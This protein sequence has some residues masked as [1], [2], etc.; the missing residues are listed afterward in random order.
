[1]ARHSIKIPLQF[2][3]LVSNFR[4]SSKKLVVDIS[5]KNPV[6][7]FSG[8]LLFIGLGCSLKWWYNDQLLTVL[9]KNNLPALSEPQQ[10][11]SRETGEYVIV[12]QTDQLGKLTKAEQD[13][14]SLLATQEE[15]TALRACF[16]N[17]VDTAADSKDRANNSNNRE[18]AGVNNAQLFDNLIERIDLYANSVVVKLKSPWEKHAYHRFVGVFPE[19]L[20]QH[21]ALT[22]PIN[23]GGANFSVI[24][25]VHK[26]LDN[27]GKPVRGSFT[28]L[29]NKVNDQG[30]E[31]IDCAC[32]PSEQNKVSNVN[33]VAID[34]ISDADCKVADRVDFTNTNQRKLIRET[35]NGQKYTFWGPIY[36]ESWFKLSAR[37]LCVNQHHTLANFFF[38]QTA[39][40]CFLPKLCSAYYPVPFLGKINKLTPNLITQHP[41]FAISP[42]LRRTVSTGCG[43][44]PSGMQSCQG[45]NQDIPKNDYARTAVWSSVVNNNFVNFN[46]RFQGK[47]LRHN[48]INSTDVQPV[49]RNSN[50]GSKRFIGKTNQPD[51]A[52]HINSVNSC[53]ISEADS[54][55]K[56]SAISCF[57]TPVQSQGS[58]NSKDTAAYSINCT[59]LA[60]PESGP[61]KFKKLSYPLELTTTMVG[62]QPPIDTL[63]LNSYLDEIPY[64]LET[65][66]PLLSGK[67][68]NQLQDNCQTAQ[69]PKSNSHKNLIEI[70]KLLK[71]ELFHLVH[72]LSIN[73]C[74]PVQSVPPQ[75]SSGL[76]SPGRLLPHQLTSITKSGA[77]DAS[78]LV[79]AVGSKKDKVDIGKVKEKINRIG[80]LL[81][82]F[83]ED[84]VEQM[85]QDNVLEKANDTSCCVNDRNDLKKE[86]IDLENSKNS[87]DSLSLL[88]NLSITFNNLS[89]LDTPSILSPINEDTL[90]YKKNSINSGVTSSL[91]TLPSAE[92][93]LDSS[94]KVVVKK[95]TLTNIDHI[96][97]VD[98]NISFS[99]TKS[100]LMSGYV[101]P[102]MKSKYLESN[103]CR[104]LS[105]HLL[106]RKIHINPVHLQCKSLR[107][108]ST[109]VVATPVA[110]QTSQTRIPLSGLQPS[111]QLG[112]PRLLPHSLI[113]TAGNVNFCAIDASLAQHEGCKSINSV[114]TAADSKELACGA[115]TNFIPRVENMYINL[116][117]R[118]SRA[119]DQACLV[120]L[121]IPIT[122]TTS[123]RQSILSTA[124][125][126]PLASLVS[127]DF[128]NNTTT[129]PVKPVKLGY[130]SGPTFLPTVLPALAGRL[131]A[132]GLAQLPE[133]L[134]DYKNVAKHDVWVATSAAV[135]TPL[136]KHA[137]RVATTP[138]APAAPLATLISQA[139]PGVQDKSALRG[140]DSKNKV[141]A[142]LQTLSTPPQKKIFYHSTPECV[143]EQQNLEHRV[144]VGVNKYDKDRGA[145]QITNLM[146]AIMA[147]KKADCNAHRYNRK[148]DYRFAYFPGFTEPNQF[149]QRVTPDNNVNSSAIN[150]QA[151]PRDSI[152][153][154]LMLGA[155]PQPNDN[156]KVTQKK[157]NNFVDCNA[158]KVAYQGIVVQR[159]QSTKDFQLQN[160][161]S[162]S[163]LISSITPSDALSA[164]AI[165]VNQSMIRDHD[166]LLVKPINYVD[167]PIECVAVQSMSGNVNG[168][169]KVAPQDVER[170]AKTRE[171]IAKQ[172]AAV[173][174]NCKDKEADCRDNAVENCSSWATHFLGPEN[175]L[176]DRQSHFFGQRRLDTMTTKSY[177]RDY[178][179]HLAKET[180]A[181]STPKGFTEKSTSVERLK[182]LSFSK[183][184][185]SFP[186]KKRKYAYL[187]EKNDEWHLLFQEQFRAALQDPKKY[188]PLTPEE[189]SS[190]A[191]SIN[192]DHLSGRIKVTAPLATARFPAK[193][194]PKQYFTEIDKWNPTT[195]LSNPELICAPALSGLQPR[196]LCMPEVPID[197]INRLLPHPVLTNVELRSQTKTKKLIVK[198]LRGELAKTPIIC[199]YPLP[200]E[201]MLA[202]LNGE[203]WFNGGTVSIPLTSSKRKGGA[204]SK[205]GVHN[206]AFK[207]LAFTMLDVATQEPLTNHSWHII[208]Q[209]SFLVALLFWVEQMLLEGVFPAL[210]ALE[211]LLLGAIDMKSSDR[212]RVIRVIKGDVNTPKFQDIAGVDGL[213]GELSELVL[214]LR[215][216]KEQL[217]CAQ[218]SHGVL[219]TGPPGTGKTFLVRALAGEAKVP[220]LILSAGAL[221]ASKV[222][223]NKPSWSIR[224]AFRRAKQLAPCILFIDELDALGASRGGVVTDI[225]EIVAH[226]GNH[227]KNREPSGQR[228]T[229]S[230]SNS[231]AADVIDAAPPALAEH[232]GSK[233]RIEG[234]NRKVEEREGISD[235]LEGGYVNRDKDRKNRVRPTE[236]Q[237][238]KSKFGPLTQLL[239]S[240]DGVN[241]LSGVLVLGAT[242]RPESL[243]PALT[244]PGRFERVIRVEKPAEEKRIEILRLYSRKLGVQQKIPW[245]YLANRTV[246][247]T[248]ADLAVAMNYS[249]LKAILQGSM[250]TVE[251]V[252]YGLD[253]IVRFGKKGTL[254]P[255][256]LR[257]ESTLTSLSTGLSVGTQQQLIATTGAKHA[258][259]E[260]SSVPLPLLAPGN[261]SST[262]ESK[263]DWRSV[264]S[265]VQ[266]AEQAITNH[267]TADE[268]DVN[269]VDIQSKKRRNKL[270]ER[271]SQIAYYQ[272][273]KVVV[274]TLLPLHPPVALVRMNLSGITAATA[275]DT[276]IPIDNASSA[277]WRSSLESRLV[278][279]YGG[280]AAS[281]LILSD[282]ISKKKDGKISFHSSAIP[283]PHSSWDVSLSKRR[284]NPKHQQ[285]PVFSSRRV[286]K[287]TPLTTSALAGLTPSALST[288]V[289]SA[290][291]Q[292]ATLSTPLTSIA[293]I[294]KTKKLMAQTLPV[295]SQGDSRSRMDLRVIH[296]KTNKLTAISCAQS[297]LGS[298]ELKA[299]TDLADRMVNEWN[300]YSGGKQHFDSGSTVDINECVAVQSMS[301]SVAP[302]P[303]TWSM[304]FAPV[305]SAK[306]TTIQNVSQLIHLLHLST[307]QRDRLYPSWFR[308]YLPDIEATELM[309]NAAD[310]YLN[311]TLGLENLLNQSTTSINGMYATQCAARVASSMMHVL[312]RTV[313][314]YDKNEMLELPSGLA[315]FTGYQYSARKLN[316]VD[317]AS[318]IAVNS[319]AFSAQLKHRELPQVFDKSA[320]RAC[321]VNTVHTAADSKAS[322][323]Q[324][325][326][327]IS[328]SK[329]TT[330][331]KSTDNKGD[332]LQ[333]FI[334]KID[335]DKPWLRVRSQRGDAK[336]I[337]AVCVNE[338]AIDVNG[339][340][341][342][343]PLATH[344]VQ[345]QSALRACKAADSKDKGK[346]SIRNFHSSYKR[347]E[348]T[349]LHKQTFSIDCNDL[350]IIEKEFFYHALV[351]NCFTKAFVLADQ[352]RQLLDYFADYLLRFQIIRQD[353][354][355]Y[356]FST[357]LLNRCNLFSISSRRNG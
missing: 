178:L 264:R 257:A 246:G 147:S 111:A 309:K 341:P 196:Q 33:E 204:D 280:K 337:D 115:P 299:G 351:T 181:Q 338:C 60:R 175:P 95:T 266:P 320:L 317:I 323:S 57:T 38:Q 202:E 297:D 40:F 324:N 156:L 26:Y 305:Q 217:F 300:F 333:Y 136:T 250:H 5:S 260:D 117:R 79:N 146:G 232:E 352:N 77:H 278:G 145:Q 274:Q 50:T 209:W 328:R 2:S 37:G 158:R 275:A 140:T 223:S 31:L 165:D 11:I 21:V 131:D 94:N 51:F 207:S 193:R 98:K 206:D 46:N 268:K 69:T 191:K 269:F 312:P 162:D 92:L 102:D 252:E 214:F 87:L 61:F 58:I 235:F 118:M 128:I 88:G 28:N 237:K 349:V 80:S 106:Q 285:K 1:M 255:L 290:S 253:S 177:Q 112:I 121:H 258:Q 334:H 184:L 83:P 47:T 315:G 192:S 310:Y 327:A 267:S 152:A 233:V 216:H 96:N 218:R 78:L 347:L 72:S 32:S 228:L 19:N 138:Y 213:L 53:A 224:H 239:V 284:S 14:S 215:G 241:N 340:A 350:S 97:T 286:N 132:S 104:W 164:Y 342:T 314:G 200:R 229:F 173:D 179:R 110:T 292:S 130:S 7:N 103:L 16:V 154:E 230:R 249:S 101:Y 120:D 68:K 39:D 126:N 329:A 277:H 199:H 296:R 56:S 113:Q 167:K 168:V 313:A 65:Y 81:S 62:W 73:L 318:E 9:L 18:I 75:A 85:D 335:K 198:S 240:M 114:D 135:S 70:K 354:I 308:L 30:A 325:E 295:K 345:D 180:L 194:S 143:T 84:E 270:I 322:N 294:A 163:L 353:K 282:F 141:L 90:F 276:Y 67:G 227:N 346:N 170:S 13:R 169:N 59:S 44:N 157:L 127:I 187:L 243:D 29:L 303:L 291:L 108:L 151:T 188:P 331:S 186:L 219:L 259:P 139:Q 247:L 27:N 226:I 119:L 357:L 185:S 172:G 63:I 36:P 93:S 222:N 189:R 71:N 148:L 142:G 100:R 272:A 344:W 86:L 336:F 35:I 201:T 205:A 123:H 339:C 256:S 301:A 261:A 48:L 287:S 311:G 129:Q 137:R 89:A 231:Y 20:N 248:A 298:G 245:A 356:L 55:D 265:S 150:V 155:P 244:R 43:S 12:E 34:A 109:D 64:K 212:A 149:F 316:S 107:A 41:F 99:D 273:G 279:L 263:A 171:L 289:Q 161:S 203:S 122:S 225:N 355:L 159:N 288:D 281:L 251:T 3:I 302:Q 182:I 66:L 208:I 153:K 195:L 321:F 160:N 166:E 307:A 134:V 254:S 283:F 17:G 91:S 49:E 271:L 319:R 183:S 242:N 42:A 343:A 45:Y 25:N 124:L 133:G 348:N 332:Q 15:S 10:K 326:Y 197:E 82:D 74:V 330:G 220:V 262:P 6:L 221:A 125:I 23:L 52:T 174:I 234:K 4:D 176:T 54:K 190:S 144:S 24:G 238:T 105:S 8:A 76:L 306:L 116:F 211:Q 304:N 22:G 210:S 293:S 236:N